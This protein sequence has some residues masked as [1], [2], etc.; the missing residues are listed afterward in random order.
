METLR[1]APP[2]D[3]RGRGCSEKRC[4]R[5]HHDANDEYRL[6]VHRLNYPRAQANASNSTISNYLEG[7]CAQ[8]D[9]EEPTEDSDGTGAHCGALLELSRGHPD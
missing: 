5:N 3:R 6:G 4:R 9:S 2:R 7:G 8:W 1:Q